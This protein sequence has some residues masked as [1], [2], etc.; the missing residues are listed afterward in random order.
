MLRK[1]VDILRKLIVGP[2]LMSLARISSNDIN[3]LTQLA[4]NYYVLLGQSP[5]SSDKDSANS[6][7]S[8]VEIDKMKLIISQ[9]EERIDVLE[10]ALVSPSRTESL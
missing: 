10:R 4:G 5:T 8:S 9:L 7:I 6:S 2:R 1:L 3:Q